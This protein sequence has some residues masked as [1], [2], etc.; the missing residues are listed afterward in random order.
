MKDLKKMS[1]DELAAMRAEADE[2]IVELRNLKK[3]VQDEIDRRSLEKFAQGL[4]PGYTIAKVGGIESEEKV[5][6]LS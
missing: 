2:K 3:A 6:G 1:E 5:G 4:P